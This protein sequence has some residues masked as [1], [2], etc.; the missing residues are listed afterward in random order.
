MYLGT[1]YNLIEGNKFYDHGLNATKSPRKGSRN[2][3]PWKPGSIQCIKNANNIII[4]KNIFNNNGHVFFSNGKFKYFYNNTSYRQLITVFSD[5]GLSDFKH[6]KFINN[7]FSDTK[8]L[9]RENYKEN[10]A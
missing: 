2:A 1:Q 7:I 3:E 4:R 6:N 10:F 5:G 9:N 8:N